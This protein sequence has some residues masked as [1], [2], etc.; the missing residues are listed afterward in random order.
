MKLR[1]VNVL[2]GVSGSIAAYRA[3]DLITLMRNEGASVRVVMTRDA[4]HF[5]T[6][7]SLQSLSGQEVYTDFFSLPGRAKPVHIELA[8]WAH[9][10]CVAP[11]SADVLAKMAC[12]LADDLLTC[13]VLA[14]EASVVVAPAMNEKMYL[15][16]ATQENL[17]RLK[18]RGVRVVDPIRGHL[19]CVEEGI[20]HLAE[21]GSI[22]SAVSGSV[23]KK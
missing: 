17:D 16:P 2:L 21:L 3:C 9:V 11:A 13:T 12:G 1:G 7:L 8:R 23:S 19:V 20:G 22:V 14:T 5:I 6:P 4:Q 10:L 15:H 18:K